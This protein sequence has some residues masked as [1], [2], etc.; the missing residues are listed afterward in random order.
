MKKKLPLSTLFLLMG[1]VSIVEVLLI[2]FG[3]ITPIL[4]YSP[5]N[6]ALAFLRL[7]IIVYAGTILKEDLKKSALKGG[8]LGLTMA[9]IFCLSALLGRYYLSKPVLG[10][11]A[12]NTP[13][14]FV[15]LAFILVENC[16]LGAVVAV[17]SSWV[18]RKVKKKK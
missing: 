7:G 18:S 10:I 16:I 2:F 12:P 5:A 8:L 4:S 6:L 17:V 15:M 14:L 3:L 11:K 1:I 9:L 13:S